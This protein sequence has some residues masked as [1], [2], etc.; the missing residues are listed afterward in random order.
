[1]GMEH[2]SFS[3]LKVSTNDEGAVVREPSFEESSLGDAEIYVETRY[4]R[5]GFALNTACDVL[6]IIL[7][8]RGRVLHHP[9]T[10]KAPITVS[11]GS[12]IRIP[13]GEAYAFEG[14][15]KLEYVSSPP[16]TPDQAEHIQ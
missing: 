8:Q 13:Q 5:E 15:M 3:E 4:P 10:G 2:I 12:K 14:P 6:A 1:M 16:W 7:E 9:D 11:R